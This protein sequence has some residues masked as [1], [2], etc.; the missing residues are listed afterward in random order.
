VS[1]LIP[2]S[3]TLIFNGYPRNYLSCLTLGCPPCVF[4]FVDDN[5]AM[6]SVCS[7][8]GDS[9]LPWCYF[10]KEITDRTWCNEGCKS[11]ISTGLVDTGTKVKAYNCAG[12]DDA[13]F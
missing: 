1:S 11:R 5:G 7:T 6:M 2:S 10:N 3:S 4:P 8:S 13:S 12:F 9:Q